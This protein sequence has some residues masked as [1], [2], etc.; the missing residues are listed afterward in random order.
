M[1]NFKPSKYQE[2]IL[3]FI[4]NKQGNLLV[5]AKAGSGKTSTLILIANE[6][7][8]QNRKCLFLAFNKSIVDELSTRIISDNCQI[9]TLHSLGLSFLRSYLY[10]KHGQDYILEIDQH[11]DFIKEQVKILFNDYCK[12]DFEKATSELGEQDKK[13]VYNNAIKEIAQ[14]VDFSRLYNIDYNDFEKLY[15]LGYKLCYCLKNYDVHGLRQYPNIVRDIIDKIKYRFENPEKDDLDKP[16]YNVTYTDMIYFPCLYKMYAPYSIRSFLDYVLVDECQDLSVLQQLFLKRLWDTYTRFIF[17]GDEKQS[18]YGFAGADTR[19]V[20][21]LKRNFTLTE[22]PLNICYR[23]PENVIRLSK[24]LVP[25]IDWNHNREDEGI[26]QFFNE[27]DLANLIQPGD[28]IL[29]RR[30]KDLVRL[31][32]KLVLEQNKPIR[33]KNIEMVNTIV[34]EI[35]RVVK[36]YINLYNTYSNVDKD[37]YKACDEKGI[38]WKLSDKKLSK[39]DQAYMKQKAKEISIRNKTTGKLICKSK[40]NIDRFV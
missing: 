10:K 27:E 19:S 39:E 18:I 17:V 24:D 21:N 29:G 2:D 15:D 36:E 5:D 37:L 38:N 22:L 31:Y 26:V 12:E 28:V 6:I 34:N 30:N 3:N 40:Y 7:I 9:K 14:M 20:Q 32:K 33:F 8:N 35:E 23:C 25:A 16:V 13:D 1:S 11:S 4:K